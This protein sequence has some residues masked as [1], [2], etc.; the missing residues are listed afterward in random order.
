MIPCAVKAQ[1]QFVRN[2][3]PT[4]AV[5]R[6][7]ALVIVMQAAPSSFLGLISKALR[8]SYDE[9]AR[10]PLP[11]RWVDLIHCLNERERVEGERQHVNKHSERDPRH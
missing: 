11:Q 2:R 5:L 3:T 4:I 10:E 6:T 8:T 1:L 9:V 7:D